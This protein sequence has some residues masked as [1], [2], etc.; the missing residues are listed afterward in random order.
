M[1]TRDTVCNPCRS[2]KSKKKNR[3]MEHSGTFW[4]NPE[5]R[6]IMIIIPCSGMFAMF[7]VPGFIDGQIEYSYYAWCSTER[8]TRKVVNTSDFWNAYSFATNQTQDETGKNNRQTAAW[9]VTTWQETK[10]W[11]ALPREPF[12]RLIINIR[13]W[14]QNWKTN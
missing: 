9:L 3:N 14:T 4:N 12:R 11:L 1:F 5:H 2:C 10:R 13:S 6:I 8:V 7:Y